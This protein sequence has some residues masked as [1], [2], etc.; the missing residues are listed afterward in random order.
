MIE[1]TLLIEGQAYI[2]VMLAIYVHGRAFLQ[3]QAFGIQD[4]LHGYLEGFRRTGWIYLL[5]ALLLAI[6]A[7]YEA[8]AA[9][10]GSIP[11]ET[12]H[13]N[14]KMVKSTKFLSIC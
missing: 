1:M 4:Q 14:L 6:A 10:D 11:P 9:T 2:L 5:V 8:K 3:P 13:F 7:V 12:G